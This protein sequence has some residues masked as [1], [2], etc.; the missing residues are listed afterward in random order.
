METARVAHAIDP[1]AIGHFFDELYEYTRERLNTN[2]KKSKIK[3][4]GYD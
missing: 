1:Q 2:F 4:L 3:Y